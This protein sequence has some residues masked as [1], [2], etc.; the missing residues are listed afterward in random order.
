MIDEKNAILESSEFFYP[1]KSSLKIGKGFVNFSM[2]SK[3]ISKMNRMDEIS[4]CVDYD[5]RCVNK[6]R[7][8]YIEFERKYDEKSE[9]KIH[10]DDDLW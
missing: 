9:D 10:L 6:I 4:A 1:E 2:W 3:K 5:P 8:L 7:T